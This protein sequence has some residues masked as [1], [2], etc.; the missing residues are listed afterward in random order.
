MIMISDTTSKKRV[1]VLNDRAQG[2]TS[3]N[4]GQV[5]LMIHRRLLNYDFETL[6]ETN[7]WNPDEGLW[8]KMKHWIVF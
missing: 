2:G 8:A 6:T 1:T 5:E 7:P 4:E 3:L